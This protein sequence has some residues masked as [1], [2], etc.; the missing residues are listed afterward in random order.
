MTATMIDMDYLFVDILNADQLEV[1][2]LIGF[3]DEIVKIISLAP[4]RY[5]YSLTYENEY[6]EKET[7][8]I[9]DDERFNLYILE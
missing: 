9:L 7:V 5:G 1:G 3:N 8:D 4:L 6:G 2:D